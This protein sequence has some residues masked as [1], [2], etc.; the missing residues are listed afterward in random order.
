MKMRVCVKLTGGDRYPGGENYIIRRAYCY[1]AATNASR[2]R[3]GEG[4]KIYA[5]RARVG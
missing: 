1:G 4:N 5:L 3:K 2:D